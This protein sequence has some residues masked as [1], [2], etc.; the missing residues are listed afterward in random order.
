M[1]VVWNKD[2]EKNLCFEY[3][4]APELWKRVLVR[5]CRQIYFVGFFIVQRQPRTL[6][7][8]RVF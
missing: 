7:R 1:R 2:S 6:P 4:L 8:H 5:V 3:F